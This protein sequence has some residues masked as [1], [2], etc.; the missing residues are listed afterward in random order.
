LSFW[1]FNGCSEKQAVRM[2]PRMGA[3]TMIPTAL[4][5]RFGSSRK[6]SRIRD[7]R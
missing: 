3:K 5:R 4:R 6:E 7:L 1:G 2:K